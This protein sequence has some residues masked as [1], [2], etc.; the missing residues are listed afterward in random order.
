MSKKKKQIAY[1]IITKQYFDVDEN[2]DIEE[3]LDHLRERG[4]AE[5]TNVCISTVDE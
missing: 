1:T 4:S 5:V 3:I 2:V